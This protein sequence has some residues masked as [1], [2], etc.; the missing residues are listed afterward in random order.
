MSHIRL[1]IVLIISLIFIS[2]CSMNKLAVNSTSQLLY[3]TSDG[4][5]GEHNFDVFKDGIA[6]NLILMEGLS[7]QSPENQNFLASLIKGYA[8]Y[9]FAINETKMFE[10]EW[11]GGK[12]EEGR[13]Q[14]LLNYSRVLGFSQRY[15][16]TKGF[17]M[18]DLLSRMN[19]D[20]GI[21]N[22]LENK[23]SHDKRDLE[24]VLFTAHSLGA[25]INLQK[26][27]MGLISQLTAVK[28]MFD[29]VCGI[30][31]TINF[32][33]C[34]IFY[35]AYESGRPAMLGG[36][37]KK[38][39]EIFLSAIEK[40]PHNW[41][42]RSSYV[43]F[44]LVPQNDEEGFNEQMKALKIFHEDFYKHY[45]YDQNVKTEAPWLRENG[46]RVYQALAL[47]RYELLN[48]YK[49]QLF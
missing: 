21:K 26:D 40:H 41:L 25:L 30:N 20:N 34:D 24:T 35:G 44:Y 13:L 1:S 19:E 27:N 17:E 43:Q 11:A 36:N 49:K 38:G 9:A 23:L 22:F 28:G 32:G 42:I 31:P 33:T 5:L 15:F 6:G 29:W 47:K 2:S 14:A 7:R 10:E 12:T 39:K 48:K 16:K 4:V 8:G 3:D 37:P 46:M 45:I 18:G